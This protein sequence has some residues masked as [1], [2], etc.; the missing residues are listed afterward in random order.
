MK[1]VLLKCLFFFDL[2]VLM[3]F[4]VLERLSSDKLEIKVTV[5]VN[6]IAF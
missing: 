3:I 2:G 1:K 6:T 5:Y 4:F